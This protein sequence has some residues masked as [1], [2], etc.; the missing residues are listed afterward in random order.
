MLLLIASV[1]TL[2]CVSPSYSS[3][4]SAYAN[5]EGITISLGTVTTL[6]YSSVSIVQQEKDGDGVPLA[7]IYIVPSSEVKRQECSANLY[8]LSGPIHGNDREAGLVLDPIYLLEGASFNYTLCLKNYSHNATAIALIFDNNTAFTEFHDSLADGYKS[9]ILHQN[10]PIANGTS[11]FDCTSIVFTSSHDS[12]YYIT[13][14]ITFDNQGRTAQIV[15]SLCYITAHLKCFNHSGYIDLCS[16]SDD[17]KTCDINLL[18]LKGLTFPWIED[19]TMLAAVE[20]GSTTAFAVNVGK[21]WYILVL[22]LVGFI[23]IVIVIL[24]ISSPV[25]VWYRW[26]HSAG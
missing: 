14:E 12:Y 19:Y 15:D 1:A 24:V 10:L 7:S 3:T 16:L 21:S 17:S 22:P 11:E 4:Y 13:T 5:K 18:E 26:R 23:F 2:A 20:E 8:C 25:I 9:S 6:W